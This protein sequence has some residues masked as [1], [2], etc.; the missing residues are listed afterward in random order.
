M[1]KAFYTEP[2]IEEIEVAIE[3]GIATSP[4]NGG[5]VDGDGPEDGDAI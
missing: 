1:K 4:G 3:N 5:W 2:L